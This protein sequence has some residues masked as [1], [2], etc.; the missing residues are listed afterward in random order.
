MTKIFLICGPPQNGKDTFGA[1]L[2]EAFGAHQAAPSDVIYMEMAER[3]G[4]TVKALKRI[5]KE[6]LRPALVE[7]G[8]ELVKDRP[9]YLIDRLIR[10]GFTIITGVR[11]V[12]EALNVDEDTE[13]IWIEREGF[14]I[15]PDNTEFE[16]KKLADKVLVFKE[17]DFDGMKK[18]VQQLH[19]DRTPHSPA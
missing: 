16:L 6:E 3:I 5:P 1:L 12:S 17:G 15:I 18:A 9:S 14:D 2:A 19:E 4:T 13:I 8:D 11:R 10:E 7:L